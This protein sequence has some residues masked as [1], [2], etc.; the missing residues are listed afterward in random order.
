[1]YIS[2]E[3]TGYDYKWYDRFIKPKQ[4]LLRFRITDSDFICYEVAIN[5]YS[6]VIDVYEKRKLNVA[7]N[8]IRAFIGYTKDR[9]RC[10]M[11]ME[12]I[13]AYNKQHTAKFYKYEKDVQKYL[14]LI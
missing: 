8:L 10:W 12:E 5:W 3:Y 2:C 13:I 6:A 14:A 9:K 1:M 7:A 11:S 4:R